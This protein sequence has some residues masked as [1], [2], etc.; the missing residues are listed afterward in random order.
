MSD[1][2]SATVRTNL[3]ALQQ[4]TRDI[5]RVQTRLATGKSV[6][7]AMDNPAAFFTS[8]A[9]SARAS[10]LSAVMDGISN[11]KQ[12]L[13]A[14]TAGID[15]LQSLIASARGLANQALASESTVA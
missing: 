10:A 8:S 6:N 3:R 11:A 9:L 15:A 1:T 12:V 13:T 4:L 5:T 14:T 7:S 2:L